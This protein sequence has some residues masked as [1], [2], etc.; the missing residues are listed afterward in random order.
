[1]SSLWDSG[2]DGGLAVPSWRPSWRR[3]GLRRWWLAGVSLLAGIAVVSDLS[4]RS[5]PSYRDSQLRGFLATA[6]GDVSSCGASLQGALAE[7][8]SW[9]RD[10]SLAARSHA[11]SLTNQGIADCGFADASVVALAS[12]Q[13]PRAIDSGGVAKIAPAVDAWAYLDGFT[14][15]QDLKVLLAHPQSASA[16]READQ[17]LKALNAQRDR[18]ER[19]V[20]AA[21]KAHGVPPRPLQLFN[22]RSILPSL[23]LPTTKGGG[24]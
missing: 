2:K 10:S 14:F 17:E 5:A 8:V 18:I 1:M 15:L 3:R 7:Y 20:V 12:A 13:P 11:T 4:V 23:S 21:E 22:A 19:L 24:T 6:S 9:V 16:A